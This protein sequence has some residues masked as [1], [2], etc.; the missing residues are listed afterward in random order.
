[1]RLGRSWLDASEELF[2]SSMTMPGNDEKELSHEGT[3]TQRF[4]K[5]RGLVSWWLFSEESHICNR[6]PRRM[7]I[8]SPTDERG[9]M[10]TSV[11]TFHPPG[12]VF[13]REGSQV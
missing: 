2:K 13:S 1:M 6:T 12:K 7:K 5:L 9:Q 11:G 4:K 3:K 8:D 10:M